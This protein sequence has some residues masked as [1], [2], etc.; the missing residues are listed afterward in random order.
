MRFA[1]EEDD[2]CCRV[3]ASGAVEDDR[4]VDLETKE[5]VEEVKDKE[6]TRIGVAEGEGEREGEG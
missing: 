2:A 6:E 5:L 3:D 1:I 4:G